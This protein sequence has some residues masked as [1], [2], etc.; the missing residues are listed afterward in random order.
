MPRKEDPKRR[1]GRKGQGGF[2]LAKKDEGPYRLCN[3]CNGTGVVKKKTCT[4]CNGKGGDVVSN[5]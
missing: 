1:G 5:I 2:G 4:A 3:T